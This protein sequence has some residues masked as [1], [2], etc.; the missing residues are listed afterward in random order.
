MQTDLP[1]TGDYSRVARMSKARDISAELRMKILKIK[2]QRPDCI[3]FVFEGV[4]DKLAF[5]HWIKAL[6][7]EIKYSPV[8]GKGKG[9]ILEFYSKIPIERRVISEGIF[10]FID[11]D[12]DGLR[13]ESHSEILFLL[14]RYSIEN[15]F[16]DPETIET[17]LK[18]DLHCDD[19][20]RLIGEIIDVYRNTL[21]QFVEKMYE[22]N[23]QIYCSRILSIETPRLPDK[24][25]RF[26]PISF[27]EIGELSCATSDFLGFECCAG[28]EEA[29]LRQEFDE[30]Y[31]VEMCRGKYLLDFLRI[32]LVKLWEERRERRRPPFTKIALEFSIGGP[33]VT[34]DS[35]AARS[36]TPAA[37]SVFLERIAST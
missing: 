18:Y 35:L 23:F 37:L 27:D 29:R 16:C 3:A 8:I 36:P 21:K 9:Q 26:M 28:E 10:L 33:D 13:R 15:Y 19:D 14:D 6:R 22:I 32:W 20:P 4:D 25:R 2:A 5:F 11:K 24:I 31:G 30:I 12:F 7:F 1:D 34:I 17:I